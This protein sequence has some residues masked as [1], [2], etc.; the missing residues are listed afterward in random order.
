MGETDSRYELWSIDLDN[1]LGKKERANQIFKCRKIMGYDKEHVGGFQLRDLHVRGSSAK[2]TINLN[3]RI[4]I[5]FLH[6]NK[7]YTWSED[8]GYKSPPKCL[9]DSDGRE[10][11]VLSIHFDRAD[12]ETIYFAADK[13]IENTKIKVFQFFRLRI[14]FSN[15]VQELIY[16]EK[17]ELDLIKTFGFDESQNTLILMK[18]PINKKKAIKTVKI[19]DLDED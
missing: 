6:G 2:Q 13:L 19:I 11:S 1:F 8:L 16:E 12:N 18:R 14:E 15:F 9:K 5:F 10:T 17:Q 3:K 7:I 4:V